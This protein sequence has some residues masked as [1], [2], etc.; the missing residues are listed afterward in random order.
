MLPLSI[1]GAT[2]R[3]AADQ[4]EYNTL[5]IRDVTTVG[6]DGGLTQFMLSAWEPRPSEL[7]TLRDGGSV[8][9]NMITADGVKTA[10]IMSPTES[11]IV[12]M[13]KGASVLLAIPG[14]QHPPVELFV[15]TRDTVVAA[16]KTT[17]TGCAIIKIADL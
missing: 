2:R 1:L 13:A 9:C 15:A 3:M 5:S 7:D 11:E 17:V 16:D 12:D 8:V 10:C 4:D 14:Q 6:D